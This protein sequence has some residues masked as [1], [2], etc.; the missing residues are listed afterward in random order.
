MRKDFIIDPYQIYETRILGGD[1]LLLIACL[2]E[3]GQ[4]REFIRLTETLSLSPLVEVHT[5]EELDKALAA[6]AQIIGINNRDLRT[7][8]TDLGVTLDLI[9]SIPGNRIVV[10]ESGINTREDI[11]TLMKAGIHS[12]LVGEALMRAEDIGRKL[13]ELLGTAG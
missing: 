3:G 6:G 8:S 2:L 1:A 12:F 13:G 5:R 7:F 11:E 4:L 10:S 9:P